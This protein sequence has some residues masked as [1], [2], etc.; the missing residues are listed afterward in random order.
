MP[1]RGR[2]DLELPRARPVGSAAASG[3]RRSVITAHRPQRDVA[4]QLPAVEVD[5]VGGSICGRRGRRRGRRPSA[6]TFSTRP[7]AVTIAPSA[8]RA[9]PAWVTYDAVG[10]ASSPVITSPLDEDAG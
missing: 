3:A 4:A 10:N 6:V 7:P 2:V 5:H 9:V 8:S 1:T